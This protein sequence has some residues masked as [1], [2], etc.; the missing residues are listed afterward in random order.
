MSVRDR[1]TSCL[2]S[3][4]MQ[5]T[6]VDPAKK[7]STIFPYYNQQV[8]ARDKSLQDYAKNQAKLEKY[9]EKE[10]TASNSVKIEQVQGLICVYRN[11]QWQDAPWAKT[12]FGLLQT[13]FFFP[14]K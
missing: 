6:W 13:K 8:K 3:S 11:R 5:R 9:E 7:F 14:E 2:Q 4:I 10:H 12:Q 1:T